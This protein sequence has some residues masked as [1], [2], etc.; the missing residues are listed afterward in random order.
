MSVERSV[1][2]KTAVQRAY[3]T[4]FGNEHSTE[5]ESGALPIGRSSPQQAPHGLYAE[6]YSGY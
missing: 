2:R 6:K 1:A 5:A 4:G 3:M